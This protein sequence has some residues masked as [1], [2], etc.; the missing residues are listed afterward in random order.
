[1]SLHVGCILN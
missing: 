1:V